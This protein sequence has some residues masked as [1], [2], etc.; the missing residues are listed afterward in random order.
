MESWDAVKDGS[1][2]SNTDLIHW[3]GAFYL[4]HASSPWHFA[5]KRCRLVVRRS[6]D[7]HRWEKEAEL[8]V[9]GE[10]IR[11]PKFAP[12]GD[13]LFL[14]ALKNTSFAAE[15]YATVSTS[16]QDGSAWDSFKDV[17]PE[18]WLFWRP[19]TTD[20]ANWY[21]PA[22]WHKHGK[23]VLL[24]STDGE[25][26]LIVSQIY[27]GERNDEVDIEFLPDGRMICTARLEGSGSILG[28]N[29]ASTLI[30]LA[31]APFDRWSYAKSKVT[32]L[33][34]PCLF[35]HGG[36]VYAVGRYQPGRRGTLTALGSVL[37]RKRTSLFLVEEDGLIY[38][39][40]LPSAGDTSYAGAVIRGDDLYI[41][42][43]T[44]DI[45][46]DYPWI[47]GMLRPSDIRIAKISLAGLEELARSKACSE[48]GS[49]SDRR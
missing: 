46:K 31:S 35:S 43:Y 39:S 34:G 4:V 1:H 5:S 27:E 19:K 36:R 30:G 24:R 32:R 44:S 8:N 21:V 49:R 2:N 45:S 14:Y 41:S 37:S 25:H 28:N 13:R 10:D 40:D 12:I 42:Y 22:Y 3:E 17:R 29:R 6:E 11:D 33:D 38:L 15:P 9:P 20:G 16:S 7:A 47:L 48:E 23:S 18:G 26:W